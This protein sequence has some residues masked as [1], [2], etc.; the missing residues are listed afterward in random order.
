MLLTLIRGG[1][2]LD[3]I[4]GICVSAFVV[5]CI[6]PIHEF[7]H[8]YVAYKMGDE[9]AKRSG[10]LTL[11]PIAHINW[12]GALMILL[13]GFGYAQPV[14]VD[15][16]NVRMKNKKLAMAIIAFAGPLS[17]L[18]VAFLSMIIMFAIS[19]SAQASTMTSAFV[20]FFQYTAL[21]NINLAVFNLIP[22][23]PLD[24]S[25]ILLAIIPTKYYFGIMK[26]EKYIMIALMILLFT[27]ILTTPLSY[28]SNAV[29]RGFAS[30]LSLIF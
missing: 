29:Y 18:I 17:N 22:I 27:G 14:P 10:R 13:V 23:P 4:I 30:L 8:G 6:L 3:I 25:R 5:F 19:K 16:R 21:I 9:T 2:I 7:A 26:Y 1:N 12:L 11:N 24:G 28:L 15:V 20:F